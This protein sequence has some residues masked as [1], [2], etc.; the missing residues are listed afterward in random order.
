MQIYY[1][2]LKEMFR[3]EPLNW[4]L[5]NSKELCCM[6]TPKWKIFQQLPRFFSCWT[7]IDDWH[8]N[9]R[10]L[11]RCARVLLNMLFLDDNFQVAAQQGAYLAK[12]FNRMEEA[13]KN[14]EGPLRFR[15]EGRHRFRPFRYKFKFNQELLLS[16]SNNTHNWCSYT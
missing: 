6:L 12:C 16:P 11:D 13:E 14:P 10:T 15:G 1:R 3:K 8:L 9:L 7:L 2:N 5:K 4:I